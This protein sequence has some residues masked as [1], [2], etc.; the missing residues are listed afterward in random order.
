MLSELRF[1]FGLEDVDRMVREM[2]KRT[3]GSFKHP[4]IRVEKKALKEEIF[5]ICSICKR[6]YGP[7]DKKRWKKILG[8]V[9]RVMSAGSHV[10]AVFVPGVKIPFIILGG[11]TWLASYILGEPL[12]E[13]NLGFIPKP[14]RKELG[15]AKEFLAQCPSCLEWVCKECWDVDKGVCKK[16]S[17]KVK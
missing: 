16:C 9:A 1:G 5:F 12:I 11:S 7:I 13:I 17:K 4:E 6:E 2:R 3:L 8:T 15:K 14:N 10:A